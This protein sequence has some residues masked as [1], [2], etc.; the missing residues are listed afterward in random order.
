MPICN[1]LGT[2]LYVFCIIPNRQQDN[3]TIATV[4]LDFTLDGSPAGN[5]YHFPTDSNNNYYNYPV[6]TNTALTNEE[7]NFTLTPTPSDRTNGSVV[8]FDYAIYTY[9]AS[10]LY[11]PPFRCR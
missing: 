9:V 10:P 6:Y 5:F 2:S 3:T 11:N 7:H 4:N 8:L 1:I